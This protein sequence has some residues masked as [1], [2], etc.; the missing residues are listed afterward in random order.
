MTRE[1]W[2]NEY[3][4]NC[5]QTKKQLHELLTAKLADHWTQDQGLN[6]KIKVYFVRFGGSVYKL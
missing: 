2:G 5:K 6:P 1:W 3:K 4:E